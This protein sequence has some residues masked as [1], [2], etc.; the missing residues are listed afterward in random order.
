MQ[1]NLTESARKDHRCSYHLSLGWF[2]SKPEKKY[3]FSPARIGF[4]KMGTHRFNSI[5]P[6]AFLNHC[7][8]QCGP[9]PS[10]LQGPNS[11]FYHLLS[12]WKLNITQQLKVKNQSIF[13]I[14][15]LN[16]ESEK[17]LAFWLGLPQA[18]TKFCGYIVGLRISGAASLW[19]EIVF[20]HIWRKHM[21][22][23][24]EGS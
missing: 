10:T 1:T 18:F 9:R 23:L 15:L 4:D 14:A 7:S 5:H 21:E 24:E 11:G 20:I 8:M 6:W 12:D 2:Q 3:E 19:L 22:L 13:Y 17:H 16:I